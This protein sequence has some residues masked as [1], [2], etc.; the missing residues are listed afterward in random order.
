LYLAF[1]L[2]RSNFIGVLFFLSS[3]V[4]LFITS[5]NLALGAG[6][7]DG[8]SLLIGLGLEGVVDGAVPGLV[9][10]AV[11]G[12]PGWVA[13]L[14]AKNSS[15]LVIIFISIDFYFEYISKD[16]I[17]DM[18]TN[19]SFHSF[20]EAAPLMENIQAAKDYLFKAYADKKKIKPS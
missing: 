13:G 9:V 3:T 19:Q 15:S 5:S 8:L 1:N 10:G 18:M 7:T 12:P 4:N 20:F 6:S 14:V 11:A 2:P 17:I 16:N